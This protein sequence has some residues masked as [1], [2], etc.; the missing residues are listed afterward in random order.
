MLPQRVCLVL[1][2]LGLLEAE[3]G[4]GLFHRGL[5]FTDNLVHS[6]LQKAGDFRNPRGIFLLAYRSYAASLAAAD[7]E[8]QAG[9]ELL[10]QYGLPRYLQFAGTERICLAEEFQKIMGGAYV[11]APQCPTFWMQYK[12]E[13]DWMD[14]PGTDSVFLPTL[15]ELI[16]DYVASHEN[17]DADRIIMLEKGK[18]IEEGTH[19]QLLAQNGKYAEMWNAQAGKYN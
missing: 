9:T 18:I 1:V 12:E 3:P 8:L 4:R 15:K 2:N 7:M 10:S 14:N 13:G 6:T 17:I 19:Q 16:D 11:L 5:I